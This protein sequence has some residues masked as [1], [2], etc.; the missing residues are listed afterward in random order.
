MAQRLDPGLRDKAAL[1][2][3]GEVPVHRVRRLQRQQQENHLRGERGLA[4]GLCHL[5]LLL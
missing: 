1:L 4:A 5:G 3:G 2:V